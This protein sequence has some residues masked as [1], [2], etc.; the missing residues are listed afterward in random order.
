V[1]KPHEEALMRVFL[2]LESVLGRAERDL[3]D[4]NRSLLTM[5]YPEGQY[6]LRRDEQSALMGKIDGLKLAIHY[7]GEELSE[8][9]Q[10]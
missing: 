7:L 4:I 8:P 6:V 3:V 2:S 5:S 10:E 1:S 9:N